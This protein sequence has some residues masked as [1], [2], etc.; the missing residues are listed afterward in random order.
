MLTKTRNEYPRLLAAHLHVE[1]NYKGRGE[2]HFASIFPNSI[3]SP[4]LTKKNKHPLLTTNQ[5]ATTPLNQDAD[6]H[7]LLRCRCRLRGSGYSPGLPSK[8][9]HLRE[10][11]S[12]RKIS[13]PVADLSIID[14][15]LQPA[16]LLGI[17]PGPGGS[18]LRSVPMS[19]LYGLVGKI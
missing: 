19:I 12:K 3:N 17:L 11:K 9:Q 18:F 14:R 15:G 10:Y 2:I 5:R 7:L 1:E 16:L 6:F 8:R 13:R 4:I